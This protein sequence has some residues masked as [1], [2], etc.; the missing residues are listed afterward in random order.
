VGGFSIENEV[1]MFQK[2]SDYKQDYIEEYSD[3]EYDRVENGN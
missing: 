1:L 2:P 3:K